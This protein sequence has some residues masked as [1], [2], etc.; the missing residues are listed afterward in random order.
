M[1]SWFLCIND[2]CSASGITLLKLQIYMY[3]TFREKD[4]FPSQEQ[5][6]VIDDLTL[7]GTTSWRVLPSID[8]VFAKSL[9]PLGYQLAMCTTAYRMFRYS[10]FRTETFLVACD[11]FSSSSGNHSSPLIMGE[12]PLEGGEGLLPS[13]SELRVKMM[14][15]STKQF[16][17]PHS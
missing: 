5:L 9:A 1:S 6:L 14:A 11:S 7:N 2:H 3:I 16:L 17:T 13:V 8:D 15:C 12:V 4:G 10:H